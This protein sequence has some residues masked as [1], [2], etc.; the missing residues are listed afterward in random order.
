MILIQHILQFLSLF[1]NFSPPSQLFDYCQTIHLFCFI[2]DR[3][4]PKEGYLMAYRQCTSRQCGEV[5]YVDEQGQVK[6]GTKINQH[7]AR[8]HHLQ[9]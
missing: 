3:R 8:T 5:E 9:D 4:A 1:F 7:L 6:H 2:H